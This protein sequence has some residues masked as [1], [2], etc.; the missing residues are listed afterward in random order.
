MKKLLLAI[1]YLLPL[2]LT[3]GTESRAAE[4]YFPH[5]ASVATW[6]TEVGMIN[7]GETQLQ[8]ALFA[9]NDTGTLVETL[10]ITIPAG[11]RTELVVGDEF[12]NHSQITNM[13]F[14][15]GDAICSGYEKFYQANQRVAI[16]AVSSV[17]TG[18]L[19]VTHLAS[20]ADW[21][22]GLAL[23]NTT[24][25]DKDLTV[26]FSD[27]HG[28]ILPLA[29][30][31]HWAGT[32]DSFPNLNTEQVESA[33]I[34]NASGVIGLELF[35]SNDSTGNNYLSGL[36][37]GSETARTLYYPHIA[38]NAQWWTGIVAYN[39]SDTQVILAITSYDDYGTQLETRT[40]S[41]S[42]K[43]KY[44]GTAAG[45]NLPEGTTWFKLEGSSPITGFELFGSKDG[46]SLGGY[47]SVNIDTTSGVFATLEQNGWTGIAFVNIESSSANVTLTALSNSGTTIAT[48]NISLAGNGKVV[49]YAEHFFTEDISGA[50]CIK[51]SSDQSIVGF[52]LNSSVDEMMLDALPGLNIETPLVAPTG[53]S[54]S[55]GTFVDK[56][57]VW[58][59][60][61]DGATAYKVYKSD[62]YNG[63]YILFGTVSS[64]GGTNTGVPKSTTRYYK[65]SAIVGGEES[66][67]SAI[68][69]G[70][71]GSS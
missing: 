47:S 37:L 23:L 22:T 40:V 46:D 9:Y 57:E 59:D 43:G 1:V 6:E 30:G 41:V 60:S 34:S 10:D 71:T 21:W 4:L 38:S 58:W 29:A 70:F 13:K 33:V 28:Y 63:T 31:E 56:I 68:F 36:L 55:Q 17:N 18:D 8:G 48:E 27:G 64:A 12:V 44:V 32:L 66:E 42:A 7:T 16:P 5:I 24:A 45:L 39:P 54:A 25:T 51:F 69:S 3:T 26:T 52:Q 35:G 20:G 53:L 2:L 62:T 11:G 67:K 14:D 65:I 49:N 50:T 19:Y 61:V 15:A